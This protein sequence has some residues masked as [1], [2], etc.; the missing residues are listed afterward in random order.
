VSEPEPGQLRR[1]VDGL[2]RTPL[3]EALETAELQT[4]VDRK[5]LIRPSM[6]Q[7]FVAGLGP[8]AQVVDIDGEQCFAYRSVYFD[9]DD[10]LAYRKA[11]HRRPDRFKVRTRTY[12]DHGECFLEVKRRD[13][14][15]RTTKVRLPYDPADEARLTATGRGFVDEHVCTATPLARLHPVLTTEYHRV[16]LLDRTRSVRLTLDAGVVCRSADGREVRLTD[17]VV[18]ETKSAGAP[19]AADRVL[20]RAGVRPVAISKYAVGMAALDPSLPANRWNPVLKRWFDA[21]ARQR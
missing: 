1:A 12:V 7:A 9:T 16:T 17:A 13:A 15:G 11:A 3:A 5:Y 8:S 10:R 20:W 6:L 18:A 2:A 4:R 14:R 19:T 21:P